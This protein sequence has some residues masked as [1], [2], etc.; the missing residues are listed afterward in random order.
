MP[1]SNA[2]AY[3]AVVGTTREEW[4][5]GVLSV[6]VYSKFTLK[7]NSY[8]EALAC[9]VDHTKHSQAPST[10]STTSTTESEALAPLPEQTIRSRVPVTLKAVVG[11]APGALA[12]PITAI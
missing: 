12:S 7:E 3:G 8:S 1:W 2:L 10:T 6:T 11:K 9:G 4:P 5:F